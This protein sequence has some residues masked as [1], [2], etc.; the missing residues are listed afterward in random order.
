MN[1]INEININVLGNIFSVIRMDYNNNEIIEFVS[2]EF[3]ISKEMI[4]EHIEYLLEEKVIKK[5]KN[6]GIIS[7]VQ[8]KNPTPYALRPYEYV[9]CEE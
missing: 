3:C 1:T 4:L 5:K 2:R 9:P 8:T 7:Y 6:K